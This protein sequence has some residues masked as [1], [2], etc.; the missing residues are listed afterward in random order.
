V[1]SLSEWFVVRCCIN[2]FILPRQTYNLHHSRYIDLGKLAL[3]LVDQS[4]SMR[5]QSIVVSIVYDT[6]FWAFEPLQSIDK[7]HL[8]GYKAGQQSGDV[9]VALKNLLS[10]IATNYFVGQ[11]LDKV[12]Q[13]IRDFIIKIRDHTIFLA[14]AVLL[15]SQIVVLRDGPDAAC[16]DKGLPSENDI[17][18]DA[19]SGP[20]ISAFGKVHHL[21]RAFHFRQMFDATLHIG[22]SETIA[23]SS[24]LLKVDFIM[25][26]FFEGL[27]S[28]QLA[29]LNNKSANWIER[30]RSS[31]ER[32]RHWSECSSWNWE[33]KLLLLEA[34]DM[35]TEGLFVLAESLYDS[36]IRSA[37][38]HKFIHEEAIA[39][40][41]A[42]TFYH[43]RG[44]H[45]TSYP[46]FVHS[47]KSYN[48]W[49][50]FAVAR[51]VET[52][53]KVN[54]RNHDIDQLVSAS[55]SAENSLDYLFASSQGSKRRS[56]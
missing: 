15:L 37:H 44:F 2:L 38:E 45:E 28:F 26:Y 55:S 41:L 22:I 31:L 14:S 33:N 18:A 4:G 36:A 17:L 50:A 16:V 6:V 8:L 25:G 21:T 19:R 24:H 51:R 9:V 40:E 29:R 5:D 48:Q 11:S 47:I 7:S 52:F 53:V 10:A 23:E 1:S 27:A 42:G 30:G 13:S 39:C 46:Y 20:S 54:F 12:L 35:Y 32:L 49:G 56:E 3:K 43:E 34:E